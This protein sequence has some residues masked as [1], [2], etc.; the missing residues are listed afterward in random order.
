[1]RKSNTTIICDVCGK[2][3]DIDNANGY[4]VLHMENLINALDDITCSNIRKEIQHTNLDICE[5]CLLK[6]ITFINIIKK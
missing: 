2:D 3:I 6:I 4:G 5:N 1:M